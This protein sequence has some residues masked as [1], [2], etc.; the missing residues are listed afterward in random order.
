MSTSSPPLR[1]SARPARVRVAILLELIHR[2]RGLQRPG[3]RAALTGHGAEVGDAQARGRER[4]HQRVGHPLRQLRSGWHH[5]RVSSRVGARRQCTRACG[6]QGGR[7]I[8]SNHIKSNQIESNQIKSN[9]IESNQIISNR[10]KSNQ[11]RSNQI[12]SNQ[13]KIESKS[14]EIKSNH[15]KTK[16]NQI[17]SKS[18]QIKSNQ[19]QITSKQIKAH[20]ITSIQI[21]SKSKSNQIESNSNQIKKNVKCT[22]W[23][24]TRS[25]HRDVRADGTA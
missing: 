24:A 3:G 17:K 14:N 10:I 4:L 25:V 9:Q 20:Q 12:I 5:M 11:I 8:K 7:K 16:T 15:I 1:Y 22:L 13:I 21:Q 19:N 18:N 6:G 23:N 2:R